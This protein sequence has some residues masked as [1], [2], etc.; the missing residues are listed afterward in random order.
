[1]TP[2]LLI[3]SARFALTG[4]IA[5]PQV[6]NATPVET[7]RAQALV[8][9]LGSP[10]YREREAATRDLAKMGRL[11]V[12][13]LRA[14][15]AAE[16]SP[17]IQRRIDLVLPAAEAEDFRARLARFRLDVEGKYEHQLPGWAKFKAVLGNDKSERDLFVELAE[18]K[19]YGKLLSVADGSAEELGAALISHYA[20][21]QGGVPKWHVLPKDPFL[22]TAAELAA[23]AFLESLHPDEAMPLTKSGELRYSLANYLNHADIQAAMIPG[24][25]PGPHAA[26]LRKILPRWLDSR[27][28]GT[29]ILQAMSCSQTWRMPAST[30]RYAAKLLA[31]GNAYERS[32]G[33][34]KLG[35][36]EFG[37]KHLTEI[38]KLFDD[39]TALKDARPELKDDGH[40]ILLGDFALGVAILL[41]GQK[42][43][44][45]GL[46]IADPDWFARCSRAT[47]ISKTTKPTIVERPQS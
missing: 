16:S 8:R 35:T 47:I 9:R 37:A 12:S 22:P 14:A 26:A 15:L 28:T 40:G 31:A 32:Y 4:A 13:A 18:N 45:Y 21:M 46:Q 44:D 10:S 23:L 25:T 43:A 3:V 36:H 19:A 34:E 7:A 27:A 29:G 20:E 24:R 30:A 11:A 6:L 1:M 41:S 39:A 17:E 42:H 33:L 38:A 2:R 5:D